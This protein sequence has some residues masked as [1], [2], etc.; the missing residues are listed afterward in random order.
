[1]KNPDNKNCENIQKNYLRATDETHRSYMEN[2]SIDLNKN[3]SNKLKYGNVNNQNQQ[4]TLEFS[5]SRFRDTNIQV[6]FTRHSSMPEIKTHKPRKT[7]R[8]RLIS[9]QTRR[10]KIIQHNP[11]ASKFII[12][13]VSEHRYNKYLKVTN[14]PSQ[15][16]WKVYRCELNDNQDNSSCSCNSNAMLEV[17]KDMYSRFKNKRYANTAPT[18]GRSENKELELDIPRLKE[19]TEKNKNAENTPHDKMLAEKENISSEK[20]MVKQSSERK[21]PPLKNF[22]NTIRKERKLSTDPKS[23]SRRTK[24]RKSKPSGIDKPQMSFGTPEEIISSEETL[25]SNFLNEIKTPLKI[26]SKMLQKVRVVGLTDPLEGKTPEQKEKILRCLIVH[27]IPL[28]DGKTSSEIKVIDKIRKEVGLPLHPKTQIMKNRYIVAANTGLMQPLEGK[29]A[30]EKIKILQGLG[31]LGIPLPEG[32]TPSEKALVTKIRL[33]TKVFYISD[34]LSEKLRKAE[35]AGLLTPLKGKTAEQK[36]NILSSLAMQGIPLPEGQTP[37]ERKFI[38]KVRDDLGLPVEP[39]NKAIRDK[40]EQAARTGLLLPL[41][42]KTTEE[43]QKILIGL[44]NMGIPLPRGRTPS[45][46]NYISTILSA[47]IQ[48]GLLTNSKK[49]SN[50]KSTGFALL[51]GKTSTQKVKLLKELAMHNIPLPEARTPSE[52]RLINMICARLPPLPK[53][54]TMNERFIK[55]A[56][57]GL[58]DLPKEKPQAEKD[59]VLSR[60]TELGISLPEDCTSSKSILIQ[61]AIKELRR[62]SLEQSVE[63]ENTTNAKCNSNDEG[64]KKPLQIIPK[65]KLKSKF[66]RIRDS[67]ITTKLEATITPDES[68]K[69]PTS[70]IDNKLQEALEQKTKN[71][72]LIISKLK[73]LKKAKAANLFANLAGKS[74]SEKVK[75][76]RSIVE[77][78]LPVPEG[79]TVSEKVLIRK[80]KAGA[81]LLPHTKPSERVEKK[82]EKKIGILNSKKVV[83][84]DSPQH[85]KDYI[86]CSYEK[87]QI[88]ESDKLCIQTSFPEFSALYT[89][90]GERSPSVRNETFAVSESLSEGKRDTCISAIDTPTHSIVC[91]NRMMLDEIMTRL[92]HSDPVSDYFGNFS[93]SQKSRY[94]VETFCSNS[95]INLRAKLYS[96]KSENYQ[97][98]S[99]TPFKRHTNI[100]ERREPSSGDFKSTDSV[101][102]DPNT[103][104]A[105]DTLDSI[106]VIKS[107]TSLSFNSSPS[108]S[109]ETA[110]KISDMGSG[111][112]S[113]SSN[114]SSIPSTVDLMCVTSL[115]E[116]TTSLNNKLRTQ[117]AVIN[118]NK[119][120]FNATH[121]ESIQEFTILR[122]SQTNLQLKSEEGKAKHSAEHF[123]KE[124]VV[125]M[126]EFPSELD[127][128]KLM[129]KIM[130]KKRFAG[131]SSIFIVVPTSDDEEAENTRRLNSATS[132]LSSESPLTS[133]STNVNKG[134]TFNDISFSFCL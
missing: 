56:E 98:N 12:N 133:K 52:I 25:I 70:D 94:K 109:M 88:V 47:P 24:I 80:F 61:K 112:T 99:L 95:G 45:E 16:K 62:R 20:F 79:K 116:L 117:P 9:C 51:E 41:E 49:K 29:S 107:E 128:S 97:Q 64:I 46:K 11:L 2:L 131:A 60:L 93:A 32:R 121:R 106:V 21:T 110:C 87:D 1:M 86:G 36:N 123:T 14:Y 114:Y 19:K 48:P 126:D 17:M 54:L 50:P 65:T 89:V 120:Q 43:K 7:T 92:H 113:Y 77:S 130:T 4:P 72:Y 8:S 55:A 10:L 75:L 6:P 100:S 30:E 102:R 69:V 101:Y 76:L 81:D 91:T 39:I 66:H 105:A 13:K 22:L 15:T 124:P 67:K 74:I 132:F 122:M 125:V 27:S 119:N 129:D 115:E 31:N 34:R 82:K 85:L 73:K 26:D 35:A 63:K 103:Q 111:I 118:K 5:L 58:L 83:K 53:E 33:R 23:G 108:N 90:P 44:Y 42:G 71:D 28:P 37:S 59:K 18:N 78:G 84:E 134:K 68:N 3:K 57:T 40:H 38:E 104:S 127:V 96:A